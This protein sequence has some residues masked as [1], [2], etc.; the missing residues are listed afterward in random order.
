[1]PSI[2]KET[3]RCNNSP[4]PL[5]TVQDFSIHIAE[6]NFR[7]AIQN[8][9]IYPQEIVA[10]VGESGSGKSLLAHSM[11]QT[12]RQNPDIQQQGNILFH[13]HNLTTCTEQDLRAIRNAQIGLMLQEPMQALNPL[14]TIG[15]QIQEAID[16][17]QALK[18][19]ESDHQECQT[20]AKKV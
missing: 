10:L 8:L 6:S 11:I 17:H 18:P 7:L 13:Q 5:L 12:H 2:H 3:N 16:T 15:Q 20:R 14:Q 9:T 4:A 1:M 19:E